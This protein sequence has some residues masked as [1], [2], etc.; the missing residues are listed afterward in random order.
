MIGYLHTTYV[1][2]IKDMYHIRRHVCVGVCFILTLTVIS[3]QRHQYTQHLSIKKLG[4][5]IIS[6]RENQNNRKLIKA[7]QT[8][9][10]RTRDENTTKQAKPLGNKKQTKQNASDMRHN[11][12]DA[13]W[14]V[15]TTGKMVSSYMSY[16]GYFHASGRT[17]KP[18]ASPQF[19]EHS[20]TPSKSACGIHTNV[21]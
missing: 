12:N 9:G 6:E 21:G 10:Q 15:M 20:A 3:T 11:T 5:H 7:K 19:M 17:T 2:W 16:L 13:R 14:I 8:K 18:V 4:G 1:Q